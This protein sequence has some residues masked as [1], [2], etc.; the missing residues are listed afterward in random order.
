MTKSEYQARISKL[1]RIVDKFGKRLDTKINH[2][3][4]RSVR[5][6]GLTLA[7]AD[8]QWEMFAY[9]TEDVEEKESEP[10]KKRTREQIR[11]SKA[12]YHKHAERHKAANY[13]YHRC[14]RMMAYTALV[15][16][17]IA[18]AGERR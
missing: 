15:T 1:Q 14:K 10:I 5:L 6:L 9:A 11:Q 4:G 16:K 3:F 8:L 7:I 13:P 17:A 12:I 2:R 18:K